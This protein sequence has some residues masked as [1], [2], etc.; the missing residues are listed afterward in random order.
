V[1]IRFLGGNPAGRTDPDDPFLRLV[2]ETARPVYGVPM[3]IA[4]MVGGSGPNESFVRELEVPI[5]TAGLGYPD[6]RAHAPD[7]NLLVSHYAKH[8]RHAARMMTAF[9]EAAG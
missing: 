5:A 6:T 7:E 4:P 8:A 2:A 3:R 1:S 9:A